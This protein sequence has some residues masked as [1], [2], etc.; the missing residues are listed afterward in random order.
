MRDATGIPCQNVGGCQNQKQD[1]YL[2]IICLL[3]SFIA[4][5]SGVS[6][7]WEDLYKKN[8]GGPQARKILIFQKFL[9][10]DTSFCIFKAK[11]DKFYVQKLKNLAFLIKKEW[12]PQAKNILKFDINSWIFKTIFCFLLRSFYSSL[13]ELPDVRG[14]LWN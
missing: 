10:F 6:R 2:L 12:S 8:F 4:L 5:S 9:N 7:K 1:V 11:N 13:I 3:L 14:M